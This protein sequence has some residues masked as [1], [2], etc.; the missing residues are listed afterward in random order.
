MAWLGSLIDDIQFFYLF[1][2]GSV[3]KRSETGTQLRGARNAL[4]LLGALGRLPL[5]TTKEY[6]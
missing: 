5:S 3:A 6:G 1:W 4:G 2:D